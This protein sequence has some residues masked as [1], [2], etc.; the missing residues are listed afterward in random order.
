V[1]ELAAPQAPA[2][3]SGPAGGDLAGNYPNPKIASQVITTAKLAD[4]AVTTAKLGNGAVT[5]E[6]IGAG[7]VNNVK[8]LDGAVSATKLAADSVDGTKVVNDSL[9]S[10]DIAPLNGDLDIQDNTITT[11]DLAT[12]SVDT[13]EVLD[14]GLSNQDVGVLFA[15]IAADGTVSN[16]SGSVTATKLSTGTYEVDFGR[17]ISSCAFTATQGEAGIGSAAGA[18]LGVTDRSGNANAVFLTT[19]TNANA[20]ADNAFQLVVVC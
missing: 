5:K 13:D 18:I 3:P 19:R 9:G 7:A 17:P 20:L 11:F 15:Q 1:A 4:V 6:K 14:F 8:I 10:D 12:D 16:S 2:I